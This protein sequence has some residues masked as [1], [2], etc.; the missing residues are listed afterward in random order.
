MEFE[1][2][3]NP[4]DIEK[5]I[6]SFWEENRYYH[7][8]G[9]LTKKKFVISIPP[10]NIT[11]SLHIGH[12]LNNTLQD[13]L[14]RK[15]KM[16]GFET[17]W[18]PG[19]DHASIGT[20]NQIEKELKKEGKTRF[21][22]GRE[23]FLK[24]A[25]QWKEKYE[26]TIINQLKALGCL[27]DWERMRFTM[28][29]TCSRAVREAFCRYYEN[30]LIYRD[31]RIINFCPRCKT[32]IS[33][34][35]VKTKEIAGRL[36]F[37]RYPAAGGK[38]DV[39][40][41]TTRPE[42]MLGDTAVAV[43]P[44]DERYK[45]LIGKKVILPLMNREIPIIA[46]SRVDK[47]FGTGAVKVTPAHDPVD[48]E[49]GQAHNLPF[50]K[51]ID[52]DA[53]ITKEG[54][55]YQGLIR[56]EAREKI[57]ED[58]K[59]EGLL[60]KE[61]NYSVP[62][63]TCVRCD[64]PTE[65]LLS[66]QWFL[67][68][69]ELAKPAIWAV[70]EGAVKFVPERWQKVYLDW[71][72]NIKDWCISRQLWWG[73]RIP[74]FYCLDCNEIMALRKDPNDCPRCKGKNIK[75][76]ED[77]LD[78]WFSSALWPFSTLGWPENT[79]DMELYYPTDVLITDPDIIFLWVA[80]M[81]FSSLYFIKKIPFHTV[82]IHSTVLSQ[83]GERMSRS[84]GIGVDPNLLIEKYGS[85]ALRFTLTYLET[86]SQ[87]FRFWEERVVLGRNFANKVWNSARLL[88]PYLKKDAASL[89]PNQFTAIDEW[90]IHQFNNLLKDVNRNLANYN[91]SAYAAALYNFFWHT[92]CDWYLEFT[93][94][95]LQEKDETGLWVISLIFKNCL[96]LLHPIMPFLTEEL[97][98]RF[99]FSKSLLEE[100]WPEAIPATISE[101]VELVSAMQEIIKGI[102]AIRSELNIN[103]KT[104]L[105]L[106]IN[107]LLTRK[108]LI[109]FLRDNLEHL[110]SLAK[111]KEI[112]LTEKR[113]PI[114]S[115]YSTPTFEFYLPLAE[116]IDV[117]KERER[118]EKE[119][120]QLKQ[121]LAKI[122]SHLRD[123]EFLKK[124]K[125]EI[126]IREEARKKEFEEKLKRLNNNLSYLI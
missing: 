22:L 104:E 79:K 6:Y 117:K 102:R 72:R 86:Q 11:G 124:A 121:E 35:E 76:D 120:A 10:P 42:T 39:I 24:R 56:E 103:P 49:I 54:G 80:R 14:I 23:G 69:A 51:V 53:R 84:R 85:D 114:S 8:Q 59:K 100:K 40:V 32:A 95:R 93:K 96:K 88:Y 25:W 19:T 38:S 30:G 21:D 34:L 46:D 78:T 64:T 45:K 125:P 109:E 65:P 126:K 107:P 119:I 90:I 7:A 37:I 47:E 91:F 15:K 67:R 92:F 55:K 26:K 43:N 36:W 31:Y 112:A 113:P 63:K 123:E 41:A 61:E 116:I 111:V 82:Y 122:E 28:D 73:H 81:V 108:P 75:Q 70:E 106:L 60:I 13:I 66:L 74:V 18:V 29:E 83:K 3:Y 101:R 44:E 50:I 17:L 98:Q 115:S 2:V 16:A 12:A 5:R 48:F 57:L 110:A 71:L 87:S 4:K 99:N 89:C 94:K 62:L 105:L 9:D 77:I 118:I 27:C 52:E 1:K 58:L 33:D 20:H 68:M 97:W